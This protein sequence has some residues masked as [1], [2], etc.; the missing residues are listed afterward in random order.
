[1][2]W[3]LIESPR[4]AGL[5]DNDNLH[6]VSPNFRREGSVVSSKQV[7]KR[8]LMP[9]AVVVSVVVAVVVSPCPLQVPASP[10]SPRCLFD[11]GHIRATIS[12]AHQGTTA[13]CPCF[14]PHCLRRLIV[15]PQPL[16]ACNDELAAEGLIKTS[17]DRQT[18]SCWTSNWK[19]TS[20]N[21]SLS[22]PFSQTPFPF[23]QNAMLTTTKETVS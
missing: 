19:K 1:M 18:K 15:A 9:A 7:H 13:C 4:T 21:S 6:L 17:T 8:W 12:A 20:H 3:H 23:R 11:L 10:T 16:I 5:E 22:I 2:E 14:C